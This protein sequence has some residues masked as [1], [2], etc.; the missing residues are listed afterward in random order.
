MLK[1]VKGTIWITE[2]GGLYSFTGF[3][4]S[5]SRQEKAEKHMFAL[6]R[7]SSRIQRLY[8][9]SWTGGG[10]FDAGLMNVNN[11]PRPAYTVVRDQLLGR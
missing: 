8:I 11:T 1:T 2:T 9:W 3:P 4:P 7:L 5:L 6:A 10:L